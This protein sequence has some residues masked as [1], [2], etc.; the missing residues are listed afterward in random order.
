M[1]Y[2]L[3]KEG[4]P[5][6]PTEKHGKVKWL[7]KLGKAKVVKV[8]PF[9]IQL[10]YES[11][12][13]V[14]TVVLGIDAG[15]Q[16]VGF[17]A[18]SPK[19]ELISGE[20]ELLK[21]QAERNKERVMYRRQRRQRLRYRKSRFDNRRKASEWLAPSIQNKLDAHVR[22]VGKISN[23]VPVNKVV[24]EVAAFDIQAIKTPGISG[25][26]YQQGEQYEFFNL[27][28]YIF[29]RDGHTCQN[30]D[31]KNKAK[32]KVLEVHHVGFWKGD[33]SDRPANLVTLC[34]KCHIP[35]NHKK[36]KFLWGWEP[37]LKSFRPE[38]FMSI[39]RWRLVNLLNC[40]HTYGHITKCRRI[41]L[42]L[43]KTHYNDAFC[44]VGG[45]SQSR[46]KPIEIKQMRRNNRSLE[47]FYDAQYIDIRTSVKEPGQVLF[48]GRR[49]RNKN[50]VGPNLRIYRGQKLVDGHRSIRKK[51][52]FFQPGD[53]VVFEGKGLAVKGVQNLGAYVKLEGLSKPVKTSLITPLYYG[54]GFKVG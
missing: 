23:L 54:K 50:L 6:M 32:E 30:P 37:K 24:V 43:P 20:L 38:T 19:K 40:E 52:Y 21:D 14:Q 13:Y 16:T 15:Y 44:I 10:T 35:A 8:K 26:E 29:H 4:K 18:V 28:E 17:S 49:T 31:C 47:K 1:V 48:S 39:V 27:R 41:E 2:V 12:S 42:K 33:R 34:D 11:K 51:R 53:T 45:S 25:V 46:L 5:L 36:G 7:L 3:S 22:L 9:T